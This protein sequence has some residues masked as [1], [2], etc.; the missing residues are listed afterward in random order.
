[1]SKH[2]NY[3]NYNKFNAADVEP[4][5][6]EAVD[7]PV[8]SKEVVEEQ[9]EL[10]LE[11][12][13]EEVVEPEVEVLPPAEPKT[14]IV[15]AEKLNIRK[16]PVAGAQ[17]LAVVNKGSKLMIDPDYETVEW[18]KVCTAAGIEGYCMKKFVEVK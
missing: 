5:V 8:E 4:A 1:M 18:I 11:P 16:L 17:V 9:V 7:A 2:H 13:V 12:A 10:E 14:G 15:T 6:R 3:T